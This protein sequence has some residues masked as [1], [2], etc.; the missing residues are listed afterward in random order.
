MDI[1]FSISKKIKFENLSDIP[2]EIYFIRH[3]HSC[4]NMIETFGGTGIKGF[5][6]GN[7]SR[8]ANNPH[9]TNFGI[10]HSLN[11]SLTIGSRL[12]L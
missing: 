10:S 3:A 7:R 1:N 12:A 8:L 5:L 9:I 6:T 11:Y 4:A 2:I